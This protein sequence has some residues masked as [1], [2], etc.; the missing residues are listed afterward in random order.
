[1]ALK[2]IPLD[3]VERHVENIYEAIVII[4]KRAKQ[5]NAEQKRIIET[6]VGLNEED[7]YDDEEENGS[8]RGDTSRFV[9]LPKPTS[10]ALKE[11]LEGKINFEY[12]EKEEDV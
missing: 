9:K 11:M 7:M 3:E 5:I 4:A 10:I 2:T 1:M 8:E 6:E 12:I